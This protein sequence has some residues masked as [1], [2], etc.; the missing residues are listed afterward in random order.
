MTK[1][2]VSI[3]ACVKK[4][5]LERRDMPAGVRLAVIWRPRRNNITR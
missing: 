1:V 3:N 2:I 4:V 5:H